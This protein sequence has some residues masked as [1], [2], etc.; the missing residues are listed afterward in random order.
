MHCLIRIAVACLAAG[1]LDC[2][3]VAAPLV[4]AERGKAASCVVVVEEGAGPTARYAAEELVRFVRESTGVAL[5]VA[6][7]AAPGRTAVRIALDKAMGDGFRLEAVGRTYRITGGARGVLYGV[8]ETLERFGDVMFFGDIRTHVPEKAA[9]AV[10]EN[11]RDSER[12]AFAG[13]ATTWKEV[14]TNIVSRTRL[15]LNL[16]RDG[17]EVP[18]KFGPGEIRF[19]KEFGD[20]HTFESLVPPDEYFAAHPEY[21]SCISGVRRKEN[22]Q[23]CLTNPEV[24]EIVAAKCIAALDADPSA[25]AVGVSPNDRRNQCQCERCAEI[26]KA[27]GSPSGTLFRFVNAVAA[28]VKE[29]HPGAWVQTLAYQYTR[30]PP[31]LTRPADNVL[32]YFCTIEADLARPIATSRNPAS[33]KIRELLDAWTAITPNLLVWAYSTNYRQLLHTFPDVPTLQDNIRYC[34]DRGV[35]WLFI[36]GGGYHSHLAELKTYLISKWLWNPDVPYGTL[37]RKFTD[38]YYGKAAPQ[39]RAY[40]KMYREHC[41]RFRGERRWSCWE[42]DP[43]ERECFPD[44]FVDKAMKIWLEDAVEAAKGESEDVRY[45]VEM[46]GLEPLVVKLDRWCETTPRVWVTRHP[47][48]FAVP[49]EAPRLYGELDARF[50][51]ARTTRRR[52]VGIG[53]SRALYQWP[54][55][56]WKALAQ[57]KRPETGSDRAEATCRDVDT[58]HTSKADAVKDKDAAGGEAMAISPSGQGVAVFF[59]MSN[60]AFDD[61]GVYRVRARVKVSKAAPQAKGEA[62]WM[63]LGD[64]EVR[65]R[66]EDVAESGYRWYDLYAGRLDRSWM[67]TVGAG[68]FSRGGGAQTVKDLRF[69]RLEFVRTDPA[70]GKGE[71]PAADSGAAVTR[72]ADEFDLSAASC[73]MGKRALPRKSVDG[74]PLT[75][76]GKVFRRGFGTHP[77]SAVVFAS[78]GKVRAFD[79]LVGLDDDSKATGSA[80]RGHQPAASFFVWADGRIV[81]SARDVV[82]GQKPVALHA[83]LRGARQIVLETRSVGGGKAFDPANGDWADARFA[84]EPGAELAIDGDPALFVQLGVLTPPEKPAPQFNG[85]DI[86]GVRPGHP[87][88]FRVP[89]SGERPMRFSAK[90][91]PEGVTLDPERGILG[92]TAPAKA[93]DYDIAVTA[94]NAKGRATRTIRL[95]VGDRIALTPPMG[96]N[97]WNVWCYRLTEEHA[98][99]SALALHESGLGDY[100]WAYVNLDDWWA[101]NNAGGFRVRK[102]KA[103]FGGREDVIGPARDAQGRILPNRSFPDMKA[104]TDYIHSFGFK[105]GIYSSPGPLTCGECEG[106]YGHE[107]QDAQRWAEWGFDYLKYDFCSYKHVFRDNA[108]FNPHDGRRRMMRHPEYEKPYRLMGRCLREQDRDIVFSMCQYGIGR[109]QEWGAEAG[110]NCWR[111]FGDI[112]DVWAYV[113]EAVEGRIGGEFHKYNG[114]G[115]WADLDMMVVGRQYSFGFDHP[116][117]LTPNE[118]YTHV[119]LWAMLCSPMLIGCDLTELDA[120]TRNLLANAAVISVSQDRLGTA[121]RRLRHLDGES[122]W[123]RPLSG[124]ATAVA[125]VNRSPVS[126]EISV[127]FDEIGLDSGAHWVMDLWRQKCEGRHSGKYVATVPPHATKLMRVRPVECPRCP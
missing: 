72:Y 99:A 95:A 101:M 86:Y 105:A 38:A 69:D 104:L 55:R 41:A 34:R 84:C 113:E 17:S 4:L 118:Q 43:P 60:V 123:A 40:L 117:F 54:R 56:N 124:G 76:S 108:G 102:R 109:T 97:S 100:G 51:K 11:F 15:R 53:N 80:K 25:N 5:P 8:Y 89:V 52:D 58:R 107:R 66:A 33:V 116:T 85:A 106:S 125:L 45:S 94:E 121:A 114:P 12:P 111:S 18:A 78:N 24:L 70:D 122:V 64:R 20:S 73:G 16:H 68:A 22:S 57:L 49:S 26:D 96:W 90:G 75:L 61:D 82:A 67:F 103:D 13:R 23:L 62:F 112:K 44:E 3:A 110:G 74:H 59:R 63:R 19:V 77:E 1:V 93:G 119:S 71:A 29:R 65:V 98:K 2:A 127:S 48:R 87:V 81:A 79:A 10:P 6:S 120:F 36:E 42:V 47:E 50:R 28:R 91:L 27:E 88:I 83:D 32:V 46:A 92:G 35:K 37:E 14:R 115:W 21:F 30:E 39:A 7:S 31:K 126:R 9:F